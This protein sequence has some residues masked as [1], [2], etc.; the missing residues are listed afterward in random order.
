MQSVDFLHP[1][2]FGSETRRGGRHRPRRRAEADGHRA[3]RRHRRA[4]HQLDPAHRTSRPG[5][6]VRVGRYGPYLQRGRRR[7]RQ[8]ARGPAAGRADPR[9]GRRAVRRPVRRAQAR[10]PTRTPASRSWSSPAGTGRTC[11]RASGRPA[12]SPRCRPDAVTL[13]EALRLLTLPRVLGQRR[14]RRGHR[15]AERAV[16]AVH[17]AGQRVPLAGERGPDVHGH[18]GRGP[19]AAGRTEDPR[20][21]VGHAGRPL[22]ELGDDPPPRSRWSSRTAGSART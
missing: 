4:R 8:R 11:P 17:Q 7:P 15:R 22:R 9:E 16:R 18:A 12:C 3:P 20:P 5:V 14:G 19:G 10:R 13:D 1:F 6:V 21:P 2:Y